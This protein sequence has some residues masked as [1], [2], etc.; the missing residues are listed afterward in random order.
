MELSQS[1][2]QNIISRAYDLFGQWLWGF[3]AV[4]TMLLVLGQSMDNLNIW[5]LCLAP[6]VAFVVVSLLFA[7]FVPP[8][9]RKMCFFEDRLEFHIFER[10]RVVTW[11]KIIGY[12]V[13]KTPPRVFS[14][15]VE[16]AESIE[17]GYF[18]FNKEQRDVILRTLEQNV[19]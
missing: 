19:G 15:H 3:I 18:T 1:I 8:P 12:K 2:Y 10:K 13:T 14:I 4:V 11:D 17:F 9:Y 7:L 16:D 6:P 5:A